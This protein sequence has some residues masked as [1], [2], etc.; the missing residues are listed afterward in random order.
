MHL[1]YTLCYIVY[2]AMNCV[3]SIYIVKNYKY[4]AFFV[5]WY[6]HYGFVGFLWKIRINDGHLF[7]INFLKGFSSCMLFLSFPR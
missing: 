4:N 1:R 7:P 6:V 2:L 3:W 5:S